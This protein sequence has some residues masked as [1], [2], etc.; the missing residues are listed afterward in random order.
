M[1]VAAVCFWRPQHLWSHS[2]TYGKTRWNEWCRLTWLTLVTA[3]T[4]STTLAF[5]SADLITWISLTP[6]TS[7]RMVHGQVAD[8]LTHSILPIKSQLAD[9][10]TCTLRR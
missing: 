8:M 5:W 2:T 6:V 1:Q 9:E 7:F 3:P 4:S 10:T